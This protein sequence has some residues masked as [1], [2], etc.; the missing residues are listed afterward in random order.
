MLTRNFYR[1]FCSS[2][3]NFVL[4]LLH[5]AKAVGSY[6]GWFAAWGVVAGEDPILL[7]AHALMKLG[8]L[9]RLCWNFKVDGFKA[10]LLNMVPGMLGLGISQINEHCKYCIC[11]STSRG[12][13]LLH[14]LGRSYFELPQSLFAIS[15]GT[16]FASN[17]LEL[18]SEGR[19]RKCVL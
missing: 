16:A 19:Q 2:T 11:K 9:P 8:W 7:V 10:I 12:N 13:S 15:L 18:W 17:A 6:E 4:L 3:F 5:F 14:I 1:R